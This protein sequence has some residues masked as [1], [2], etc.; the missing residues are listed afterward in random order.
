MTKGRRVRPKVAEVFKPGELLDLAIGLRRGRDAAGLTDRDPIA[1]LR[2]A[3]AVFDAKDEVPRWMHEWLAHALALYLGG[4][5][6]SL[7]EA[8]GLDKRGKA[9]PMRRA[10]EA[11]ARRA[12]LS[13]MFGLCMCG[14]TIRDA[15]VLEAQVSGY[16][17]ATLEGHYRRGGYTAEIKAMQ[18]EHPLVVAFLMSSDLESRLAEYP[19]GPLEVA[20][21]K[22]AIRAMYAKRRV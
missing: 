13:G 3:R 4:R 10:K 1:R 6:K 17:A 2:L 16:S 11:R 22:A 12:A 15:A 19:D 18:A 14:A 20:Q 5:A 9:N 7:D 21:A 8:F